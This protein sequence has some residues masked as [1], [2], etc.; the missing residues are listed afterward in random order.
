MPPKIQQSLQQGELREGHAR[1]L[2]SISDPKEQEKIWRKALEENLSVRAVERLAKKAQ[3]QL[4]AKAG[5]KSPKQRKSAY[6]SRIESKLREKLG[7]QV[8]LR[9]KKEGGTIEI[10]FYSGEDLDRLIDIFDQIKY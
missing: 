4:K 6:L 8:K 7:T 1:A 3:E 10:T 5:T 9:T 2:L